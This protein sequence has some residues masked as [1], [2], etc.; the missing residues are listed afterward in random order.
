MSKYSNSFNEVRKRINV[1]ESWRWGIDSER[2][3][4]RIRGLRLRN[5]LTQQELE[6][7]FSETEPVSR[8]S[9]SNWEQGK[10]IPSPQHLVALSRIYDVPVDQLLITKGDANHA[11]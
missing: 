10:S 7:I 6:E 2:T 9:I 1:A 5:Q 3:G 8:V 4:E 11:A